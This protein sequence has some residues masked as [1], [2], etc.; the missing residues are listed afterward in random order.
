MVPNSS[1]NWTCI[2]RITSFGYGG[3]N[4]ST[5]S[6]HYEYRVML[7]GLANSPSVFQ[8]FVNEVFWEYLHHFDIIYI[9]NILIYSRNM[10][11][12]CLHFKQVRQKLTHRL[13]LKLE[14]KSTG[15]LF[16][17]WDISSTHTASKWTWGKSKQFITCHFH[18]QRITMN[19]SVLPPFNLK[20]QQDLFSINIPALHLAQVSVLDTSSH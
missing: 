4:P 17:S 9:N 1:S 20:F 8:G 7:Y 6:G 14:K 5:P 15:H 18:H 3:G 16:S 12:H 13:Y 10:A 19:L 11:D 2:V